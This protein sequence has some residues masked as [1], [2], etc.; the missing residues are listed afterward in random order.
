MRNSGADGDLGSIVSRATGFLR[1]A[2]IAAA[3]GAAAVGDDYS[4]PT[5]CPNMVYELLLGGVLASVLVPMLV[6]ARERD[7]DRGEAYAQRLLTLAVSCS[8]GAT[9]VAVLSAPLLRGPARQL[10]V[11]ADR[12]R[13]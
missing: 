11:T 13:T 6:R 2:A 4:S 10:A 12:P 3:I 9:V 7:P 8:A 5:T 1:T